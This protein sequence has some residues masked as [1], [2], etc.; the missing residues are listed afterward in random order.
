MA[1]GLRNRDH[2]RQAA[3]VIEQGVEL[4]SGLGGPE[5]GPGEKG[6]AEVNDRG[7]KTEQ[8]VFERV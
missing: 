3:V 1:F 4:D 6:Q 7:V 8:L 5:L 2:G